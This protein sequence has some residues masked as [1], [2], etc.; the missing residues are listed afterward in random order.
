[1]FRAMA[2]EVG[3]PER[4]SDGKRVNV[5]IVVDGHEFQATF[6]RHPD[7]N[8]SEAAMHVG[9][10]AARPDRV[11]LEQRFREAATKVRRE[12]VAELDALLP[13]AAGA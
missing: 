4:S 7:G 1:M 5:R 11:Q 13:K 3:A 2:E 12:R 9:G 10:L 6:V 8:I